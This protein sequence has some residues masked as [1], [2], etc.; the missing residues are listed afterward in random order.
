MSWRDLQ[1]N[2]FVFWGLAIIAVIGFAFSFGTYWHDRPS[3][4]ISYFYGTSEILD[5]DKYGPTELVI[6][7]Q[8]ITQGSVY[9]S[10]LFIWNSGNQQITVDDLGNPLQ[11]AGAPMTTKT[12]YHGIRKDQ[13]EGD[14]RT[15]LRFKLLYPNTGVVL[16]FFTNN[17]PNI[18]LTGAVSGGTGSSGV[19][20]RERTTTFNVD[21]YILGLWA[22]VSFVAFVLFRRVGRPNGRVEYAGMIFFSMFGGFF[23]IFF[24][25]LMVA[26]WRNYGLPPF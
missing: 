2:P 16:T 17:R 1:H 6:D 22:I 9:L 20:K 12:T 7:G 19:F 3:R 21:L 14:I 24:V 15:G 5:L 26:G 23:L 18:S 13:V 11:W 25:R 4:E 8:R 10:R